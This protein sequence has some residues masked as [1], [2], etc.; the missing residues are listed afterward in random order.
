[1]VQM[2][3]HLFYHTKKCWVLGVVVHT[4]SLRTW[5]VEAGGEEFQASWGYITTTTKNP[6]FQICIQYKYLCLSIRV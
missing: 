2:V 6:Q 5:E 1:V 4:C 3:V